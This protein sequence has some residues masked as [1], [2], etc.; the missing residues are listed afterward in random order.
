MLR[1]TLR[2]CI[3][4]YFDTLKPEQIKTKAGGEADVATI[5]DDEAEAFITNFI[6]QNFPGVRVVGEEAVSTNPLLL[7][8]LGIGTVYIADPIDG[9]IFFKNSQPGF[10]I[11]LSRMEYGVT[12]AAWILLVYKEKGV[13]KNRIIMAEQSQGVWHSPEKGKAFHK[14]TP[15]ADRPQ[16]KNPIG[17]ISLRYF[18]NDYPFNRDR[19]TLMQTH[20]AIVKWSEA[21][22]AADFYSQLALGEAVA[23]ISAPTRPWDHAAGAMIIE[24]LGGIVCH[25]DGT[26]YSPTRSNGGVI[27]AADKQL[28]HAVWRDTFTQEAAVIEPCVS[29]FWTIP[30]NKTTEKNGLT[31]FLP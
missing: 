4:P 6:L 22:S 31:N 29:E 2:T 19:N 26:N 3:L 14:L 25:I 7:Q 27:A 8:N 5:A 28:Y 24:A 10:G 11:L 1:E 12:N 16:T 13:L 17:L 21:G 20:D 9:T 15:F 23:M 18:E 30:V